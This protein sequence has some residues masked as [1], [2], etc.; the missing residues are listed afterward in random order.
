MINR[1]LGQTL[2]P[3][4]S[5]LTFG[6]RVGGVVKTVEKKDYQQKG[7]RQTFPAA[8]DV[9]NLLEVQAANEYVDLSP[10]SKF[11]SVLFLE[12]HGCKIISQQGGLWNCESVLRMLAWVNKDRAGIDE[13]QIIHELLE[14]LPKG[15]FNGNGLTKANIIPTRI[16]GT[17]ERIFGRYSF[18]EATRQFLMLPFVACAVELQIKFSVNPKCLT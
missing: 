18:D 6:D 2:L 3:Y 8:A 14:A 13:M 16:L 12:D 1:R 5:Q 4:F 17:E 11:K 10:N 7:K 9:L 15:F